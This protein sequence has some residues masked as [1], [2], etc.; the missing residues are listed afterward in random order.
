MEEWLP[1][2]N[3]KNVINTNAYE[4]NMNSYC[5]YLLEKIER[6]QGEGLDW[7]I[8]G[9]LSCKV[10]VSRYIPLRGSSYIDLPEKINI[11]ILLILLK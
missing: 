8:E 5:K 10:N 9:F 1:W 3:T 11:D 6:F 7:R 4:I 2:I